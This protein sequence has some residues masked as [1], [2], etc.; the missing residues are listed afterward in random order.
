SDSAD[1]VLIP[2]MKDSD[3]DVRL[4]DD[5]HDLTAGSDSDVKLVGDDSDSDVRLVSGGGGILEE[6]S[7]SDVKLVGDDEAGTASDEIALVGDSDDEIQLADS[8]LA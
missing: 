4:V 6:D 3:S 7:D 5:S 8:G 1:D 2:S